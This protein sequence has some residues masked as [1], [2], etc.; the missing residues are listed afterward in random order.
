MLLDILK[1]IEKEAGTVPTPK[2]APFTAADEEVIDNLVA[3]LRRAWEQ[4]ATTHPSRPIE[5]IGRLF[6][7]LPPPSSCAQTVDK[8]EHNN[9]VDCSGYL[10]ATTA[11]ILGDVSL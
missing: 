4:E 6:W 9:V 8:V 2:P 10:N 7:F 5:P 3:R 1:D 11:W